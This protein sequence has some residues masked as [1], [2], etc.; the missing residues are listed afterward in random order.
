[1]YTASQKAKASSNI[2]SSNMTLDHSNLFSF[3]RTSRA[4]RMAKTLMRMCRTP[5]MTKYAMGEMMRAEK[6]AGRAV[7]Y[8]A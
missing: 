2:K 3:P 8:R 1:M 4:S 7:L 6:L 5:E